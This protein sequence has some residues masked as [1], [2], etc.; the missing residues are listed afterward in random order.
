MSRRSDK[1]YRRSWSGKGAAEGSRP[2]EPPAPGSFLLGRR[3]F[4]AV[5]GFT[6]AL[7]GCG[8]GSGRKALTQVL[9]A[10]GQVPGRFLEY[11]S[12]CAACPAA[13]GLLVRTRDGRPV[14][15]EGLPSSPVSRGGL[16]PSGQASLLGLY[17]KRRYAGPAIDGAKA[18]WAQ[19]DAAVAARLQAPGGEVRLLSRTSSSP[20]R[21]RLVARF[22]AAV[23]GAKL[24]TYDPV[25]SSA[26]LDAHART[27]G[28]RLLPRVRLERAEAIVGV[29][30]DFLGTWISPVGHMRGWAE[31]RSMEGSPPRC[32]WH[33]QLESRMSVTG[34]KADVRVPAAPAE[35]VAALNGIAERVARH[36]GAS[37]SAGTATSVPAT[38]LD[39]AAAKLWAARGKAVLLCGVQD[40]DAQAVANLVNHWIGAYGTTLDLERPSRQ[41][42]GNDAELAALRQELADGKVGALFVLD[43]NPAYELPGDWAALLKKAPF[44]VHCAER[45]DESSAAAKIVAPVPHYLAAWGD[46]EPVAGSYGLA[47]P[48]FPVLGQARTA[49]ESLAAWSGAPAPALALV[50]ETWKTELH[51]KAGGDFQSFWDRAVHDGGAELAVEPAKTAPFD[52]ATVK[53][54]AKPSAPP[55]GAFALV[56]YPKV[57]TGD[58]RHAYNPWLQELPDP[59]TK[60]AWDNYA[61]LSPAD[62]KALGVGDGD[63]VQVAD[64][65]LSVELPALVQ[66]GQADGTVAVALGYGSRLSERF[67]NVGPKWIEARPTLG[68]HG[69]VGHNVAPFLVLDGGLLRAAGRP[70][71]IRKTGRRV[72]LALSQQHHSIEVPAGLAPEEDRRRPMIQERTLAGVIHPAARERK[73]KELWPD[74]HKNAGPGWGLVIDLNKCTGCSACVVACQVENNVPV[75]GKDEVRRMRDLQWLRLDRYYAENPATPG[76]VDVAFQPMMCH[77]CGNAPC[78]TVCPVLATVRSEDGLNQQVYNRCVGTRYCANN[79]PY[80]VRR[81]NWFE[82]PREDAVANL[83]LNPDVTVR[84]RGV[85]EKCSLC[86]HRIQ[87]AKAE[88]KRKGIPVPDGAIQTAC[89]QSCPAGAIVFGDLKDPRTAASRQAATARS[90]Q[91]LAELNVK[92]SVHYR[93]VVRNRPVEKAPR[94]E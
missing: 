77:H 6:F 20:T 80:K 27:H 21:R 86:V 1:R 87:E 73:E 45:E 53:P 76:G 43:G 69:R 2:P 64:G 78:E 59:I 82:Y 5:T 61:C 3:R 88:A 92:P 58:G 66:P 84:S 72:D 63:V 49:I 11:A 28:A 74:D 30:A 15:L 62:A 7:A 35:L 9:S 13:C 68:E 42:A 60:A 93:D 90:Y 70:A 18:T 48:T 38:W 23:P 79:C 57:A 17:D 34:A 19:V 4:L 67:A 81:F 16:C 47:Q 32:S 37:W 89:Q 8:K 91:V 31:G 41:A 54:A 22:L 50:Q 85:M 10:A 39:E 25:S 12:S 75:V 55:S 26:I 40:V 52:P 33:L 56:L 83:A 51:P 65:P 36:A 94:H 24:V 46:A 29:D 14:K 44:T 71:S